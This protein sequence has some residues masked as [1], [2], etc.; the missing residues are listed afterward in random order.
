M[1]PDGVL[2]FYNIV[3]STPDGADPLVLFLV[4][5]C[6]SLVDCCLYLLCPEL[7][8]LEVDWKVPPTRRS[9]YEYGDELVR[10]VIYCRGLCTLTIFVMRQMSKVSLT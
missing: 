10:C 4:G 9:C 7:C 2:L 5:V 6:A 8:I 3:C 1:Y